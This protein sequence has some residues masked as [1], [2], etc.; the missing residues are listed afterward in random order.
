MNIFKKINSVILLMSSLLFA[1]TD[2]TIRGKITDMDGVGLPAASI[3]LPE[4]GL[5]AM[6]N[7]EGDYIILN[8]PVGT[9]DVV[10]QM[11]GYQKQ[12]MKDVRVLM[13][14]TVWLNFKLPI[15]TIEG[16][17]VEVLGER[18]MVEKGT[19]SKKVTVS[20]EAIQSLPIR[21]LSDLYS[22]QSGVVK[23]E[24]RTKG[25]PDHEER[26][27]EEIHVRG[28]RSGEVSYM[29]D[30]MYLRNPI[31]GGIGS[32]TRLNLF[33]VKEFD[34]Q[35]GGFNAEYGDA[36]SAVSN[37]HTNSG[38]NEM[39]YH[40]R[41][42]TSLLGALLNDLAGNTEDNQNYD[43]LR[44]YDDY[45]FGVGGPLLFLPKLSF[46]V[47]GQ[48]TNEANYS[49][50]EFDDKAYLGFDQDSNYDT[51]A[52]NMNNLVN[53][54]DDVTGFRGFGYEKTWDVFGKLTYKFSNKL[55][56]HMAY[57]QVSNQRMSFNP[58][59]LYWDDGR[60]ELFRD[61]YRYNFEIN[62]SL[63]P[64]TF[65]SVRASR[66]I[67]DQFTGVRWRDNDKDGFPNWFEWRHSAGN[68]MISDPDNP[69]VIP[70][71]VGEDGDTIRYTMRDE[72]SGW[73]HG[74]EPGLWNWETAEDFNDV[75]GNGIF[76]VGVDVFEDSQDENGNGLWDGPVLTEALRYRDGDYWLAPEMYE[77][78][79]NFYDLRHVD[80]QYN[81]VPGN[82]GRQ[83]RI[84]TGLEDDPYY[85]MMNMDGDTWIEERTFGGHDNFF[86]TSRAVTDEIRLD[87]TSQI[88]D[89]WK[90]RT[91]FD[92]KYHQLNFY[93]VKY[94]WM[95]Q[96]AFIQTFAEYWQDTGV[97]GLLPID[98][99]YESADLGEGNGRW[100]E[101]EA[102]QDA[103]KNGQWDDFR[104]PEEFSAYV[105]NT[106]EVP[107]MVINY[108]MRVDMVNYN[109]QIWADTL[110]AYSPGRPWFFADLNENDIWDAGEAADDQAGLP[111]QKV[112]LKDSDWFYKI[113]PRLGIS[114]VITDKAMFTFNYG[115]YY[116]TPVYQNVFLNTNRIADPEEIFEEGSE[117]SSIGNGTMNAEKTQE[118]SA[119]FNVQVTKTWA[120]GLLL[121][122]KD[123]DQWSRFSTERSGVYTYK[124]MN[125][126][127][128]GSAKGIDFTLEQRGRRFHSSL[129]YTLSIAKGNGEYAWES[130]SG[131]YVDAPS[132]EFI[133]G[134]DRTHDLTFS[135]YTTLPFGLNAGLTAFY[136]SGYPYTPWIF[137]GRDPKEDAANINTKRAPAYKTVNLSFSKY[138]TLA[139]QR[140]SLGLN[141]YNLLDIRNPLDVY[142]LSGKPGDPGEYYTKRVGLPSADTYLSSAYYD[143]P[144]NYSSP[145][146][147][148]FYIRM[149]F[150]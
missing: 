122:V 104:E 51:L 56:F 120:F 72:R 105:Q 40:F 94:P 7:V 8:I 76:D 86:T 135:S 128:Y 42:E 131:V 27:L 90:L 147:F 23:V 87:I 81:N 41:Y 39:E 21:N 15:E 43:R 59:Y 93:E 83:F 30:G 35:P 133:M 141:V 82:I 18:P 144:W 69:N 9:Y 91:G 25:V 2:G 11:V 12:T 149:D 85:Y 140:I 108:G 36:Q 118:Y 146:E 77:D 24:S 84:Y 48:Y 106:Y 103:N 124:V 4:I 5:G 132:Q 145:R 17:E 20:K 95:G 98:E 44:G 127:D 26:G 110:D 115:L 70:Y 80:I 119:G 88:T 102:F 129:Q 150:N 54:W 65:Y 32:G 29:M 53:P 139:R 126:G 61:T 134:Y 125:N 136:Q 107:W 3:Y 6:A 57:W 112:F 138:V 45:N 113:S 68:K 74:A 55:R 10:V 19:T 28:G 1:G 37:W 121:W 114:H 78:Y 33:A 47:S 99:G 89:N 123:M 111:H 67:Q 38:G 62:Q 52:L 101:G 79:E 116:Q 100:D 96:A 117:S 34:W 31:F 22:L 46:W 148:N 66:F 75:N 60:N 63:T 142:P 58:R 97:D 64:R 14:Q 73:Y 143:N 50:Y 137:A 92:Y 49:V 130:I 16:E 13:D 109:T 71:T